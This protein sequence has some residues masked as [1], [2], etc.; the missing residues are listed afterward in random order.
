MDA[1]HI[2]RVQENTSIA[3]ERQEGYRKAIMGDVKRQEEE[4][5]AAEEEAQATKEAAE[6]RPFCLEGPI[7]RALKCFALMDAQAA[8]KQEMEEK[9]RAALLAEIEAVSEPAAGDG[10]AAFQLTLPGGAKHRRRFDMSAS[11]LRNL[12]EW[13][14]ALGVDLEV[15]VLVTRAPVKIVLSPT[16]NAD[17]A[18]RDSELSSCGSQIALFVESSASS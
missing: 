14:D 4:A 16:A 1:E 6:V 10:V 18:L 15:Q 3:R 17:T 11:T 13:A 7:F 9:R 2:R 5:R 12:Y 8:E